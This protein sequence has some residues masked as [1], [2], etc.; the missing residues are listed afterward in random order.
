M[1]GFQRLRDL[2]GNG[3]GFVEW[4]RSPVDPIGQRWAF[5]QFE[6]QRLGITRVF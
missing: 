3:Q 6:D 1:R 4:D 2:F 5:D